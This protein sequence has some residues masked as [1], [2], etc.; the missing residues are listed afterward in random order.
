MTEA[1]YNKVENFLKF[2]KEFIEAFKKFL[3]QIGV[4]KESTTKAE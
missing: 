2:I 3:V 1:E 4:F